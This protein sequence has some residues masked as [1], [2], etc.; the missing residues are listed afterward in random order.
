MMITSDSDRRRGVFVLR[1][2]TKFVILKYNSVVFQERLFVLMNLN[3][4]GGVTS[5]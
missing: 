3:W 5:V 1:L 4:D 2:M